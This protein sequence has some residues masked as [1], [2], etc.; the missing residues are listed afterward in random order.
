M[1]VD[2][3]RMLLPNFLVAEV[4]GGSRPYPTSPPNRSL[5]LEL[6]AGKI[7]WEIE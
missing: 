7:V 6:G 4:Y 1:I 2:V 3:Y 5:A